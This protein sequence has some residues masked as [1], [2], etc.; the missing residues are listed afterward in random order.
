MLTHDPTRLTFED[1]E[2]RSQHPD[3]IAAMPRGQKFPSAS[4]LSI[5]LS[6]SASAR[7]FFSRVFDLQLLE[8]LRIAGL[9]PIVLG[10]DTEDGTLL[11]TA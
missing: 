1:P 7:S 8:A 6:S 10:L 3:C 11:I 5:A 9:H 4:S 2:P